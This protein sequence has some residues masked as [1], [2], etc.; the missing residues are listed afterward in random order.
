MERLKYLGADIQDSQIECKL[1]SNRDEPFDN[2]IV[3]SS[4]RPSS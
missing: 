1:L 4:C 3:L 2:A